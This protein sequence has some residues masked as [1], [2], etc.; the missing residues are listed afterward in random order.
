LPRTKKTKKTKKNAVKP[1]VNQNKP[2]CKCK[3]AVMH[4][5]RIH[6]KTRRLVQRLIPRT[7]STRRNRFINMPK[8]FFLVF[9]FFP[10]EKP[11]K[12]QKALSPETNFPS[13]KPQKQKKTIYFTTM[14][15][16]PPIRV[17]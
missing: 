16:W 10:R 2:K 5:Q 14:W 1:K 11:P 7:S 15:P 4:I 17:L 13:E 8:L 3:S 6:P 12:K 9:G